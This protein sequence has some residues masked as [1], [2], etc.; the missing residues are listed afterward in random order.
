MN[1]LQLKKVHIFSLLLL[2]IC[3]ITVVCSSFDEKMMITGDGVIRVDEDVRIINLE[4]NSVLNS[5]FETYN[6]SYSK[7]T[8]AMYVTLPELDST[9]TYKVT[10]KNKTDYVYIVSSLRANIDNTNMTYTLENYKIGQGIS[11]KDDTEFYITLKY[12]DSVKSLPAENEAIIYMYYTFER[13]YAAILSYDNRE[14][15]SKCNDVQCA[16]DD[17]YSILK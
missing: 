14:S 11:S 6:C 1:I 10:V 9:I 4:M 15:G 7:D 12:K 8:T 17:L 5:A 16:L 13:P 2:V 3:S